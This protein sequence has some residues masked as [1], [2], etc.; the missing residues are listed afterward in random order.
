MP[1]GR[2]EAEEAAEVRC[3]ACERAVP[4][5]QSARCASCKRAFCRLCVRWYGHFMLVCEECRAAEW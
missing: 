4:R 5:L 2:R 1:R 3:D